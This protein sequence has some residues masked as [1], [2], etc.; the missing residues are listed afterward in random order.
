MKIKKLATVIFT[1]F[2]F[3]NIAL[4]R[5]TVS[6]VDVG[7]GDCE[8]I[9]LPSG[10]NVLIDAG[11]KRN[12]TKLKAFLDSHS[13]NHVD[14][15]V[16]SHPDED[17]FG[18][19]QYVLSRCEVKNFYDTKRVK[20]NAN[21]VRT[22]A[23]MKSGCHVYYPAENTTLSWDP[24]VKVEVLSAYAP[25]SPSATSVNNASI[26]LKLTYKNESILFTGDIDSKVEKYLV[27]EYGD[28]LSA[29]VLKVSHHGSKYAS[30]KMFLD[31]VQPKSSYI[32]VD[33]DDSL[34]IRYGHPNPG[35]LKRLMDSGSKIYRTDTGGTMEYVIP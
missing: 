33:A 27:D 22:L 8:Y 11:P 15:L 3:I 25:D 2:V 31:Q 13:I 9:V 23:R 29:A 21:N 4:A 14:F 30:S 17:H 35:T 6:F 12:V 32:E 20:Q 5:M 24:E 18:G 28:R 7:Q 19:I 34:A 26:V 16:L 1:L 10:K